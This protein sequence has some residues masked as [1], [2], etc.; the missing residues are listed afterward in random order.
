[1]IGEL[2]P[3]P[4]YKDS[5]LDWLSLVPSHRGQLRA[6][7]LLCEVD[8]RSKMGS[9]LQEAVTAV[10]VGANANKS[11]WVKYEIEQSIKR[12]NGVLG[13]DI[14]KVAD[15]YRPTT[16]PLRPDA[17]RLCVLSLE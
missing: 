4:E 15:F 3:Y 11:R 6:K 17:G 10:L 12:G 7:R 9:Q 13:I 14:S 1:M 16:N 8:K 2:K 5:G